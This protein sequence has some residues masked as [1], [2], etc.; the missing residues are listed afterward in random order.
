M[1]DKKTNKSE[2]EIVKKVKKCRKNIRKLISATDLSELTKTATRDEAVRKKRIDERADV[3][4]SL[5]ESHDQ[6]V[7]DFDEATED[8]IITVDTKLAQKLK[9]HQTKGVKF[10]FDACFESCKRATVDTG[11]GC[12]LAHCMGLGT[13]VLLMKYFR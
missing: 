5:Y 8:S 3:Y 1:K 4:Q 10:M 13:F 9:P 2:K 7:L 12:I 6:L 11:S